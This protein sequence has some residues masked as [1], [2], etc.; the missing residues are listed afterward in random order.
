MGGFR[1]LSYTLWE[2]RDQ[3]HTSGVCL[4]V[5][6]SELQCLSRR[7]PALSPPSHQ[8]KTSILL[9]VMG[10]LTPKRSGPYAKVVARGG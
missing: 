8:P 3:T 6:E 1:M 10:N 4:G 2:H 7:W 9:S 5:N